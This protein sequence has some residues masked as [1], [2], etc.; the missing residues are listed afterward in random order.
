MSP[1]GHPPTPRYAGNKHFHEARMAIQAIDVNPGPGPD[2]GRTS[3][4]G[5]GRHG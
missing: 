5:R 4:K 2:S 3:P 1:A